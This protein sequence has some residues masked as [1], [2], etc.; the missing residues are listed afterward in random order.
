M[1][2]VV[3]MAWCDGFGNDG[4]PIGVYDSVATARQRLGD[5]SNT[6]YPMRYIKANINQREDFDWYSAVPLF[7]P[8]K[9]SKKRR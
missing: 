8:K 6:E 5:D 4:Y 2:I 3:V 7:P 1:E 9:K